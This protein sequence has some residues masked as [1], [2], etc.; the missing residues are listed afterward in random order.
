MAFIGYVIFGLLAGLFFVMFIYEARGGGTG[1]A[2]HI[3]GWFATGGL[4]GAGV[5]IAAAFRLT[6]RRHDDRMERGPT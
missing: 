2:R 5:G 1:N 4:V 6:R 3:A